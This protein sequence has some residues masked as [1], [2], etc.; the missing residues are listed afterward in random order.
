M[1]RTPRFSGYLKA[2]I[3]AVRECTPKALVTLHLEVW[4]MENV[5][6]L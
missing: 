4:A 3:K 1:Q 6:K 2:G 5:Q